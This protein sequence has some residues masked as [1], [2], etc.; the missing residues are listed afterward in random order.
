MCNL[1]VNNFNLWF[2][3]FSC[4]KNWMQ[5]EVCDYYI[6]HNGLIKIIFLLFQFEKL[7]WFYKSL[8]TSR[9]DPCSL[10]S[11][12]KKAWDYYP[13]R[14]SERQM[15]TKS[16]WYLYLLVKHCFL[17]LLD[18]SNSGMWIVVMSKS[19]LKICSWDHTATVLSKS[20]QEL[21]IKLEDTQLSL[22]PKWEARYYLASWDTKLKSTCCIKKECQR[23]KD[24]WHKE[25]H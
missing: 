15:W 11:A 4:T 2:K 8:E 19:Y 13:V 24:S 21:N 25:T 12:K 3:N 18:I 16:D 6:L 20:R 7:L 5:N 10:W 14:G 22:L 1:V 9:N 17:D 23:L